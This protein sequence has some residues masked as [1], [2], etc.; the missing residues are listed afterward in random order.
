M[1]MLLMDTE[2]DIGKCP[3]TSRLAS[4]SLAGRHMTHPIGFVERCS[5][6]ETLGQIRIGNP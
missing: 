5:Q 2:D 4:G 1:G 6:V 3:T